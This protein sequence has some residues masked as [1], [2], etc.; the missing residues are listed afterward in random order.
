MK[1]IF[2]ELNEFGT[3][4]LHIKEVGK[5]YSVIIEHWNERYEDGIYFNFWREGV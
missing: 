2:S 3:L 4:L 1:D 5:W